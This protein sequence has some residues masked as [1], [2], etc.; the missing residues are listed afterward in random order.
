MDHRFPSWLRTLVHKLDFLG[1]PNLGMLVCGLGAL[2]YF[3]QISGFSAVDRFL[4][5]PI[6]I[7]HQGEWWR[8][9][10]F[11]MSDPSS[12]PS[13]PLFFFFFLLFTYFI[14]SSI[15][16]QWG[17]GPLTVFVLVCYLSTIAGSLALMYPTN[18]WHYILL[19]VSLV[20]GTLFPNFEILLFFVLP[21]KAKWLTLFTAALLFVRFLLGSLGY[22]LFLLFALFPYFLFFGSFLFN[23]VR[24]KLKTVQNRKKFDK[25]MW[26]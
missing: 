24:M 5:D 19:N 22:K 17:A 3:A 1:L 16:A 18:I 20:F 7:M 25:D 15:E 11:P 26:R 14:F 13:N 9:F 2:A 23:E 10:A 8:L 12:T 4:F 21:V 6:A